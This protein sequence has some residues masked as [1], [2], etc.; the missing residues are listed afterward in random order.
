LQKKFETAVF[1]ASTGG[2]AGRL[3]IAA[4]ILIQQRITANRLQFSP[5]KIRNGKTNIGDFLKNATD[6]NYFL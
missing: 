3:I 2:G 6:C 4:F 5:A 1:S